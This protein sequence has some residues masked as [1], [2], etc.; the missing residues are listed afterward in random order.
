MKEARRY[1]GTQNSADRTNH[2]GGALVARSG[3][4][5]E[6]TN[7]GRAFRTFEQLC[8]WIS[9][10]SAASFTVLALYRSDAAQITSEF[11]REL[12]AL[13]EVLIILSGELVVT[14]DVYVRL[15]RKADKTIQKKS[16]ADFGL[17]QLVDKT[18]HDSAG[19]LILRLHVDTARLQTVRS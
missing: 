10:N 1:V 14:T 8:R 16:V 7:C 3:M 17:Q 2:G 15:Y 6:K 19:Y 4:G 11:L 9:T 12:S 18:T 13:L 5:L